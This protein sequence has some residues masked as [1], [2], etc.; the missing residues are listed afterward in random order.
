M[1]VCI[2]AICQNGTTI[3]GAADRMI[4][5]GNVEFEV[6]TLSKERSNAPVLKVVRMN[7][8]VTAMTSGDAGFQAEA[9]QRIFTNVVDSRKDDKDRIVSSVRVAEFGQQYIEFCNARMLQA[10]INLLA[11]CGLTPE[12]FIEKQRTLSDEF[13]ELIVTEIEKIRCNTGDDV[14]FCGL[15]E[16]GPHILT[17]NGSGWTSSDAVGFAAIGSG[18]EHAESQ[19]M[20]AE[21]NRDECFEDTAL[22]TYIAKRRSQVSPG[23]GEQTDMFV[24]E[25]RGSFFLTHD[26]IEVLEKTYLGMK[27][28]QDRAL[29]H[30]K[31]KIR[32]YVAKLRKEAQAAQ[33][34]D[35]SATTSP[36]S[37]T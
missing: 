25:P 5:A 30:A 23:V 28:T 6:P 13:V 31:E 18:A 11:P 4:T 7:K 15:D 20:L 37:Q 8:H 36:S 10:T 22:L 3:V 27:N 17:C 24:I 21:H 16:I 19:L 12:S 1:T 35:A 2:A 29:K 32:S 14:I 26:Q 34:Q 33:I 9:I